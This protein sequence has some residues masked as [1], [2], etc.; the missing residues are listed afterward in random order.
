MKKWAFL[1]MFFLLIPSAQA[2]LLAG[3][4]GT[5]TYGYGTWEC[6]P[7]DPTQSVIGMIDNSTKVGKR[8]GSYRIVY[9]VES[10]KPSYVGFWIGLGG[11]DLSRYKK[12]VLWIKGSKRDGYTTKVML[13]I[14]SV[15]EGGGGTTFID[16]ITDEWQKFEVPL[17]DFNLKDYKANEF[18]IVIDKGFATSKMGTIFVDEISVE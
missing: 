15:K 6:D 16:G 9:D 10:P 7:K 14:E 17:D 2:L 18:D 4:N 5:D 8:G 1:I 3:F 12:L 11:L 13:G